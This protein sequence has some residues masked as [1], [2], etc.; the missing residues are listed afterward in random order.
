ERTD[1]GHPDFDAMLNPAENVLQLP[2][3]GDF[4]DLQI[5]TSGTTAKVHER[6]VT[7]QYAEEVLIDQSFTTQTMNLNPYMVFG[8][9]AT[10]RLTPSSDTW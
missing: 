9:I 6:L 4:Y 3:D 10:I 5:D 7:S 8:N 1:I 2:I